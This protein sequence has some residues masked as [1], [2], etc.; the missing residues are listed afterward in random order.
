M[1]D[2][3]LSERHYITSDTYRG[4]DEEYRCTMTGCD[5]CIPVRIFGAAEARRL[6]FDHV[7][8]PDATLAELVGLL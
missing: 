4:S 6:A 3:P 7:A 2:T 5:I 1:T 8:H